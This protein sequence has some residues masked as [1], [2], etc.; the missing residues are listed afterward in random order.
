MALTLNED[1]KKA[2]EE[3][4]KFIENDDP[5]MCLL[6]GAAGTG[7]TTTIGVF[8][9]WISDNDILQNV[10][11]CSPTHKALKVLKKSCPKKC[12]DIATFSTIHS[13]LGLR[14]QITK[15][16][17]EI[18]VRDKKKMSNFPFFQLVII[19]ESSMLANQLFDEINDQNYNHIKVLFV[20]D[21]NQINPVNHSMS[22]PMKEKVREKMNIKHLKLTKIVRQAENN[23]I[24][25]HSQDVIK[26]KFAFKPGNKEMVD[27]SGVVMLGD[28]KDVIYKL[29][30]YYFVHDNF[31]KNA[32]YCKVI[33]WR[34][35]T[36]DYYNKIIR[37]F[38]YGKGAPKIVCDEKLL[39]EKPITDGDNVLFNTND[40]LV[41][42]RIDVSEKSID[43]ET[44]KCYRCDVAC[45]DTDE[46]IDIL[47]EDEEKRF[48]KKLTALA[49]KAKAD[50]NASTRTRKWRD[51][52]EF[53]NKFANV[54]YNYAITAHN[55]QGSTYDNC[56]V[57]KSDIDLN[58]KKDERRRI[59]YTAFTRPKNMLYI[60]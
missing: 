36:V 19:D 30:K 22:M 40:D 56:F 17:E 32:D 20:G 6:E 3:L 41:V 11:M 2:F 16:G 26:E 14:H 29:L 12:N 8:L 27:S 24:I 34:N 25:K 15:D 18:F 46:I 52:Y 38:K 54:K 10:A 59:T 50:Q 35:L 28:Q 55:S 44:W 57:I 39:V 43:R 13:M 48:K 4:K 49:N 23:P 60:I 42:E 58:S 5:Y 47:H 37:N 31:D 33:A 7:K 21:S 51:Y 53:M 9:E 45:G 1:Q